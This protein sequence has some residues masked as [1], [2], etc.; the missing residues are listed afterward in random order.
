MRS[1]GC[2]LPQKLNISKE[3]GQL[4]LSQ[5]EGGQLSCRRCAPGG[6]GEMRWCPELE[7]E[8]EA[9]AAR[10]SCLPVLVLAAQA[11]TLHYQPGHPRPEDRPLVLSA[12]ACFLVFLF[13][14][15]AFQGLT[16]V[17]FFYSSLLDH[18]VLCAS[19]SVC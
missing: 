15:P 13:V 4:C 5:Q 10:P 8:S 3:T 7:R 14:E 6:P 1:P 19:L 17:S 18:S 2:V 16:Q 12:P 9:E 11:A